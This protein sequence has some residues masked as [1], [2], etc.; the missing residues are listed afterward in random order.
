MTVK[1][2]SGNYPSGFTLSTKYSGLILTSSASVEGNGVDVLGNAYVENYGTIADGGGIGTV[3]LYMTKGGSIVNV[4]SG[5]PR[6]EHSSCIVP[7]GV[8]RRTTAKGSASPMARSSTSSAPCHVA[9]NAGVKVRLEIQH[10][11]RAIKS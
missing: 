6:K 3:G 1:T 4:S 9:P 8:S 5:S 11:S 10:A 7:R 2:I